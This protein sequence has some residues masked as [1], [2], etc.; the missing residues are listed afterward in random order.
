MKVRTENFVVPTR[1]KGTYEITSEIEKIVR[2][3]AV[4]TG[5]VTVF[6][7]HTSA[8]L[9]L[10]ENADSSARHDLHEFFER[11]VP[12]N[13]DYFTH[14]A[15]GGDDSTSHIRM[16]LTRSSEVIPIAHGQLQLGVWQ[17]LFVFEHRNAPHQ[18]EI[19]VTVIGE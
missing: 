10:F 13:A 9:V 15:E 16:A 1:G 12:E 6:L 5:T 14:T 4:Q 7:R 11:T 17:G 8:S 3:T 19:V 18:R 2:T